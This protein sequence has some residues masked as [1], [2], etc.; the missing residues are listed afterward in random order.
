MGR[1]PDGDAALAASVLGLSGLAQELGG[2]GGEEHAPL[3]ADELAAR[4]ARCART[5][6]CVGVD[7]DP[8]AAQW[9]QNAQ[10]GSA[11]VHWRAN[12]GNVAWRDQ[13]GTW[14]ALADLRR[15][16]ERAPL[17]DDIGS[18]HPKPVVIDG[19]STPWLLE[20][21]WREMPSRPDG[22]RPPILVLA[23][24]GTDI[25]RAMAIGTED[26]LWSDSRVT[27]FAGPGR[28]DAL[29]AFLED[30]LGSA[31]PGC[32]LSTPVAPPASRP[33]PAPLVQTIR[34]ATARQ[35]QEHR[36]L[37][38]QMNAVYADGASRNAWSDG[39]RPLRFLIPTTRYSTF[40]RHSAH[41]LA[42]A[43]RAAGH[44]ARV[45]HEESDS[46]RLV[47][48]GYLRALDEFRPDAAIL[49]NYA[50]RHLGDAVPKG[51][52]VV[53][54]VQDHMP[55]LFGPGVAESLGPFDFL[56]GHMHESLFEYETIA[57]ERARFLFVPASETTFHDGPCDPALGRDLACDIAYVSHQSEPT[58]ALHDRLRAAFAGSPL[59][60]RMIDVIHPIIER[61]GDAVGEAL[62]LRSCVA[63]DAHWDEAGLDRDPHIRQAV[64]ANYIAP[65]LERCFRH[66]TLAWAAA[67][68][69]KLSLSLR[70]HGNGWDAHPTL[71]R[72]AAPALEHGEPLR[73]LYQ[74][75]HVNL[76]ISP[77]SNAHQR[78]AECALSGGLMLRRGPCPD[79]TL[80]RR[81]A[82]RLMG[83]HFASEGTLAPAPKAERVE[84]NVRH[85]LAPDP[86]RFWPLFERT[87][88]DEGV[89]PSSAF[90]IHA[91]PEG[92]A[93]ASRVPGVPL[94]AIPD[95][96]F[97]SARETLFNDGAALSAMI[98]RAISDDA[99]RA[100]TIVGHRQA[101]ARS[102]TYDSA[103]RTIVD[104]VAM[105]L[106]ESR[107]AA[108]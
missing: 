73:T 55:H 101:A 104:M 31:L 45:L 18:S 22:Y 66:A 9:A 102:M 89:R 62:R 86:A 95:Y 75:A 50:R 105:N 20:R 15:A 108:A 88:E 14:H 1:A 81:E 29:G 92:L 69:Q 30:R 71:A 3:E 96:A 100:R 60:L 59:A 10:P 77:A 6:H 107:R 28:Y 80:L 72:Y 21:V 63:M 23:E 41:D 12:D 16:A 82:V 97:P 58:Q 43:L 36:T 53:T 70:I 57:P 25:A 35:Q 84:F 78:V 39:S 2:V 49:I 13:D 47:T 44:E 8:I 38:L 103:S 34:R 94:S 48:V 67:C 17:P 51:L 52:P 76:H 24:S 33:D 64:Q 46:A 87:P 5:A 19:L 26:S 56:V 40:V 91:T 7:L 11:P 90:E 4:V 61:S 74:T 85:P 27:I 99:W 98:A 32:V 93:K 106:A 42:A 79:V 37:A 54:W 68:A 65:M 83:A